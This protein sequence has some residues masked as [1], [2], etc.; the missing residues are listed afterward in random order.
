MHPEVRQPQPG[1]CPKCGMALEPEMP[2]LDEAQSPEL[3][4]FCTGDSRL[5]VGGGSCVT[6]IARI[7]AQQVGV[8]GGAPQLLQ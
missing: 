7:C 8:A 2:T 1:V 5:A 3:L 4:D 6:S